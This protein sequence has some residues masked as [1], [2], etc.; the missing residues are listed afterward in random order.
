MCRSV[1]RI[2]LSLHDGQEI[3]TQREVLDIATLCFFISFK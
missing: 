3:H 1:F 2:H